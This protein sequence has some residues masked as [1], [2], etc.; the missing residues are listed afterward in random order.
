MSGFMTGFCFVFSINLI[1]VG[2][3]KKYVNLSPSVLTWKSGWERLIC[4]RPAN[5]PIRKT[6]SRV[7]G[8]LTEILTHEIN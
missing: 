3:E 7:K 4:W 5:I 1:G 6:G 8:W 2:Q